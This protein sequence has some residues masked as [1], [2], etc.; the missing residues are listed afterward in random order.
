[1]NN[2]G[3]D[4][5]DAPNCGCEFLAILSNGEFALMRYPQFA[6]G[7]HDYWDTNCNH[8]VPV[9]ETID[10]S[11]RE[12]FL[13]IDMW[14]NLPP[15]DRLV[16]YVVHSAAV[17]HCNVCKEN[18]PKAWLKQTKKRRVNGGTV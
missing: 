3:R 11:C 4:V 8:R 13:Q 9:A 1:M 12:D 15:K 6:H 16:K 2:F 18:D 17:N 10:P 7:Y 14:F 5:L